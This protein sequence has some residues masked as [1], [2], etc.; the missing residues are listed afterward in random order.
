MKKVIEF[1]FLDLKKHRYDDSYE[2]W[3]RGYE[4]P[5][6]IDTILNKWGTQ[7]ENSPFYP[8]IHNTAWGFPQNK[9]CMTFRKKLDKVSPHVMYSDIHNQDSEKA[10][11]VKYD[12][13]T[14]PP[15]SYENHFD[16]VININVIE[17]MHHS[18][19]AQVFKNLFAQVSPG[20]FLICTFEYPSFDVT[21][22]DSWLGSIFVKDHGN[23]ISGDNVSRP[24]I[25]Y[26]KN[27]VL[28]LIIQ[29]E[30]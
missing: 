1:E 23:R 24:D 9:D 20:G 8:I 27:N 7:N 13:L 22:I 16:F 12:I 19:R 25:R 3:S 4:Y 5:F 29:K 2:H 18:F 17:Y 15:K 10:R 6:V 21:F 30:K 26:T 14:K 11:S 28:G